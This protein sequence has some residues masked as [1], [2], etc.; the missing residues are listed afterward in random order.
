MWRF[1][2]DYGTKNP[3]HCVRIKS[4]GIVDA[5]GAID[6]HCQGSANLF[7]DRRRS[8][9]YTHNFC[10]FAAFAN[11]QRFL[12]G[13]LVEGVDHRLGRRGRFASERSVVRVGY[14]LE[15]NQDLHRPAGVAS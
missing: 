6:T 3:C 11:P 5:N 15:R 9:R 4:T 10:R 2:L 7:I 12:D 1:L 13:D 14:A 8:D